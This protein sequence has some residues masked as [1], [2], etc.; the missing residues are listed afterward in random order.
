MGMRQFVVTNS[1]LTLL[2]VIVLFFVTADELRLKFCYTTE[3]ASGY[4]TSGYQ[5]D[6]LNTGQRIQR[7]P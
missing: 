4:A 3:M 5:P 1:T 6:D 2:M 7:K